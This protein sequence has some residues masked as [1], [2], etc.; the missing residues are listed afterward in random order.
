MRKII[1]TSSGQPK[2]FYYN[3]MGKKFSCQEEI[4]QYFGR[5]GQAVIPGLFN[6][7]PPRLVDEDEDED[8]DEEMRELEEVI[9][10][11]VCSSTTT[12]LQQLQPCLRDSPGYVCVFNR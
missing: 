6:F 10:K 5:L 9:E 2:V 4:E 1:P 7:E 3:T 12:T 11:S 8:E